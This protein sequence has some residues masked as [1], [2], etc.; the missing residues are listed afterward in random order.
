MRGRKIPYEDNHR[1]KNGIL[2]KH[3]NTC[4][5][6]FPCTEEFFYKSNKNKTDGLRPDCK[7]CTKIKSVKWGR[8]N[9]KRK[10]EICNKN[11]KKPNILKYHKEL[12]QKQRDSGM[13][14]DWY[15]KKKDTYRGYRIKYESHKH[16]IIS[17]KDWVRCKEFF[18]Y[19]CAYC[20]MTEEKHKKKYHQ[21]LHKEHAYNE[22]D[23]G[24]SNCIPSCLSCNSE[25]K[26]IDW[27]DWFN[28]SNPKYTIERYNKIEEWLKNYQYI[29]K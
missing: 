1:N 29:I 11:S 18:E 24:I 23:N 2:E 27:I 14:K 19:K 20:S 28:E 26:K 15:Q 13:T 22:G 5:N 7:Q 8:D 6:W 12:S 4:E 21:Q 3:C 16:H 25:K 9:V 10:R 17:E